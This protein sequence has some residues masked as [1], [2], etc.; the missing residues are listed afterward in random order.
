MLGRMNGD[1][2]PSLSDVIGQSR[3]VSI[4]RDVAAGGRVHHAWIFAGPKGVGKR[5]AAEAFA[6]LLLDPTSGPNL[7][8]G[9][10]PDPESETQRLIARGAHP[11]LHIITKELA[12]Y[13][14]DKQIRDRKLISIP[15]E[16]IETHLLGPIARAPSILTDALA[17]KVFIVDEAELL[18]RSAANAPVQNS[19]LK[20][21]EEPPAGSIIILVTSAEDRLLPTI[22]SRCQRVVFGALDDESMQQWM[23]R[24]LPDTAPDE[25]R[26][27]AQ[28]ADGAPGSA[29]LAHTTGMHKWA[30]ALDPLLDEVT[31][32]RFPPELG[33]TMAK[34]I[35]E[36][37]SQWVKDNQN[38]SKESATQTAAGLLLAM[39]AR[40]ARVALRESIAHDCAHIHHALRSIDLTSQAQAKLRAHVSP[41]FAMEDLAAQ[42]TVA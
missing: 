25:R 36:W 40:R 4:L 42:L 26:W 16:V 6:G 18:D 31:Q 10:E 8:G 14:D 22:R 35:D 15:K 23:D 11:D 39:L 3:A 33:S 21:L 17:T 32:G 1:R 38:A 30:G 20:T 7:T 12:R 28:F 37:A 5:L 13:S 27:L 29:W 24:A 41:A 9:F 34:L 19:I 2:A